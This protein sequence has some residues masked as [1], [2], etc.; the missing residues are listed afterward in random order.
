MGLVCVILGV[1]CGNKQACGS[2]F[3][4][5]WLKKHKDTLA[6]DKQ[7]SRDQVIWTSGLIFGKGEGIVGLG[8]EYGVLHVKLLPECALNFVNYILELLGMRHCA[9]CHLYRAEGRRSSWDSEGN[10]IKDAPFGPP[11]AL[12]Q[13]TL[14]MKEPLSVKA[15]QKAS[16]L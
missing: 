12:I 2:K 9:S 13:G 10:H 1:F 3:G 7:D 5:C 14:E 4:E 11:F 8:T 6:S 15:Q 16:Q